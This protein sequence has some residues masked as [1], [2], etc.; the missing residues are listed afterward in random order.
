MLFIFVAMKHGNLQFT[1]LKPYANFLYQNL[2]EEFASENLKRNQE[3]ELP[4]LK[5][6]QHL[7]PEQLK[8]MSK[9]SVE[10]Y[11]LGIMEGTAIDNI[12]KSMENWKSGNLQ[13]IP[14]DKISASD[15]KHTLHKFIPRYTTDLS[16]VLLIIDEVED[17]FT[18]QEMLAIDTY[19]EIQQEKLRKNEVRL[20]EAQALA[21][22]GYWEYDKTSGKIDWSDELYKIYGLEVGSEIDSKKIREKIIKEDLPE[23]ME[24]INYATNHLTTFA[25]EYRIERTKEEIRSIYEYGYAEKTRSG[26]IVLRR[27]SLDITERKKTEEELRL[28]NYELEERVKKEPRN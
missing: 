20:K 25:H 14:K 13:G 3:L 27:I 6:F 22:V 11:L 4:I 26:N 12:V 19:S 10:E 16:Q 18:F 5:L 9:R 28:L 17:F 24:K 7:P 1:H 23:L 21:H 15:R 8:Q 2:L